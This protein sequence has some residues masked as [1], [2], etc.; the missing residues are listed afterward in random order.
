MRTPSRLAPLGSR[1]TD[2][3]HLPRHGGDG[4]FPPER[5]DGHWVGAQADIERLA[6]N[7]PRSSGD[8]PTL[9]DRLLLRLLSQPHI[10][11]GYPLELLF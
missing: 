3:P 7:T 10:C 6:R 1:R 2:Q 9:R 5:H 8:G 11:G 4:P